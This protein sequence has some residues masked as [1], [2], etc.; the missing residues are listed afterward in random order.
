MSENTIKL[1]VYGIPPVELENL[2]AVDVM[3][4]MLLL[5]DAGGSIVPHNVADGFS[6]KLVAVENIFEGKTI[7]DVYPAWEKAW[8]IGT[9]PGDVMW[10]WLGTGQNAAIGDQLVSVGGGHLAVAAAPPTVYSD[11]AI[12]GTALDAVNAGGGAA[13]IKVEIA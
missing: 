8:F 5:R 4:G 10:M 3:P 6:G 9:R 11:G 7:N 13:R 1:A 2:C 12:V